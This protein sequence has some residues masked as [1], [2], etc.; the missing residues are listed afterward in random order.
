M[1]RFI[2][3]QYRYSRRVGFGRMAIKRAV[4]IYQRGF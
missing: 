4:R 1:L 2:F 3:N